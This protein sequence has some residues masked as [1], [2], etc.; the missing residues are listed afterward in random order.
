MKLCQHV[1]TVDCKYAGQQPNAMW[2]QWMTSYHKSRSCLFY[3]N[4]SVVNEIQVFWTWHEFDQIF[5]EFDQSRQ[6]LFWK[7]VPQKTVN[8]RQIQKN[9]HIFHLGWKFAHIIQ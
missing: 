4:V 3:L 8:S 7:F 9:Q 6:I 2:I 1:F 5:L